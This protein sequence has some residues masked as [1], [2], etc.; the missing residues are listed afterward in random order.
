MAGM[1]E[2]LLETL[3]GLFADKLVEDDRKPIAMFELPFENLA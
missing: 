1:M 2:T 3:K